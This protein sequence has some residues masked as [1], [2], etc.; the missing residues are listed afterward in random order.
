MIAQDMSLH[1]R[2]KLKEADT[3]VERT[4]NVHVYKKAVI[5]K[6]FYLEQSGLF[7]PLTGFR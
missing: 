2:N 6:Y 4:S 3:H 7:M 5:N 1:N